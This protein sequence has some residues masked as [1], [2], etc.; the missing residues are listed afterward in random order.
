MTGRLEGRVALVTGA[1]RG[2]GKATAE[3]F[4]REGAAVV[5]NYAAREEDARQV[6]DAI[7]SAGG[8]AVAVQANVASRTEVEAMAERTLEQ[9]GK[10]DVLV[11]NAGI[12][13]GGNAL[14]L[15]EESLDHLMAVNLK[16]V[17]NCVQAVGPR[18]IERGYGK[19][20]NVSSVAGLVTSLP[21]TTP[22]ALTKAA[23]ITLTKRLA[24][25]LG[26]H[27]INVNAICPG[28]IETDMS[29]AD[30]QAAEAMAKKTI[31]GRRGRPEDI[32]HSALYL[33]SDEAAF[34]T[35]QVHT[36]DGGR[37]DFL[38]HGG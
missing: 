34:V 30:P 10:I 7:V 12:F 28:Q 24:M 25:E 22:Y 14:E 11:N 32:A 3:I 18:M 27:G 6:V 35:A 15:V 1:S 8:Q 38:S 9:F 19:I 31:L 5:V 29:P 37:M 17:I 26:P 36:V 2:I 33:A 23:V 16:G 4:A 21:N 20:V 13:L